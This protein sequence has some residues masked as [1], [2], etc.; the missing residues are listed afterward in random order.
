MVLTRNNRRRVCVALLIGSGA[1]HPVRRQGVGVDSSSAYRTH[2]GMWHQH[3]EQQDYFIC[4]FYLYGRR[5]G[6]CAPRQPDVQIIT[7]GAF[8][9]CTLD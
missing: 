3:S 6:A 2:A 5:F 4:S 7:F 9:A 8:N 1:V